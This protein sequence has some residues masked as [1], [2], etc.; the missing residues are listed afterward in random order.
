MVKAKFV[1]RRLTPG[2]DAIVELGRAALA[3]QLE[4]AELR[5][6]I[7]RVR[8]EGTPAGRIDVECGPVD[9]PIDKLRRAM[10][11]SPDREATQIINAISPDLMDQV[12]GKPDAPREE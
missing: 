5:G 7:R 11:Y 6:Y 9:N 10:A 8:E 4:A 3:A 2:Q 12:L 1:G